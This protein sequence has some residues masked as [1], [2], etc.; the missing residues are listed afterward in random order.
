MATFSPSVSRTSAST[1][2][3]PSAVRR[4]AWAAPWPRAAPVIRATRP[5][6]RWGTTGAAAVIASLLTGVVRGR[7][8]HVGGNP[9]HGGGGK[10]AQQA[11]G[12]GHLVV[13]SRPHLVDAQLGLLDG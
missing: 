4:R 1:T 2:A 6:R 11:F 5:A 10:G 8:G 12:V 7:S 9:G 3:A 13:P